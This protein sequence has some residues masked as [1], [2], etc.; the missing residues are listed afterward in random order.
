MP[1]PIKP[2][3]PVTY[4]LTGGSL[5]DTLEAVGGQLKLNGVVKT[6]TAGATQITLNAGDGNDVV[7]IDALHSFG[8]VPIFYD[9][10]AGVDTIDF[11]QSTEGVAVQLYQSGR[12][13][14]NPQSVLTGFTLVLNSTLFPEYYAADDP[15]KSVIS[16]SS[17]VKTANLLNFEN[18]IGSAY[19]DWIYLAHIDSNKS[20]AAGLKA[21][22]G[23]GNDYI[24][25]WVGPDDLRGGSGDDFL[26][27]KAGDDVLT[28]GTGAD[29]FQVLTYNGVDV[30]TDFNL[31][32]GD[33]LN[34]AWQQNTDVLPT[35][36]SWYATTW[37]DALGS[38]HAAIRADFT[39]GGVILVDHTLDEV[40]AVMAATSIFDFGP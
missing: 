24:Q 8:G 30:V 35:S 40:T 12:D 5:A 18:V 29:Q 25:G 27:G 15:S 33:H 16:D 37:T 2:P 34:I 39:G 20:V 31:A 13:W 36:A 28:G 1:K 19:D 10:G 21:D 32:E 4:T 17:T 6:P 9:G 22:G 14:L 38:V 7:R 23:A 11:S 26:F 3:A